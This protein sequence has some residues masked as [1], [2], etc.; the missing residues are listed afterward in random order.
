MV[1]TWNPGRYGAETNLTP[2]SLPTGTTGQSSTAAAP[3]GLAMY[4]PFVVLVVV[5]Y[6]LEKYK[7]RLLGKKP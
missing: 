5:V 7:V 6:A 2:R 4:V 3:A 1:E